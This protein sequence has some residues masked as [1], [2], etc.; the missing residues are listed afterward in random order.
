[1]GE[2]AV[3]SYVPDWWELAL[4][5][6]AA[7]RIFRLVA[8]DTILD[9]PRRW[10]LRLD[11]AWEQDGDFTGNDYRLGLALFITCPWC[12]GFWIGLAWWGAWLLES[13]WTLVAATPWALSALVGALGR[14]LED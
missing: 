8:D 13:H 10:L 1:M 3:V 2:K 7:Y 6:L 12:I 11:P 4:L 9:R 5:A 14:L